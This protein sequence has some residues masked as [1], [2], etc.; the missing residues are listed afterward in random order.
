MF[1]AC[2]CLLINN[3]AT[4]ISS[5]L[6]QEPFKLIVNLQAAQQYIIFILGIGLVGSE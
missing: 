3:K 6:E 5:C 2:L 1:I 4:D